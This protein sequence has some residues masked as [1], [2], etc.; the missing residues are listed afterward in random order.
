[1]AGGLANDFA[2]QRHECS[3]SGVDDAPLACA[4]TRH[5][6][7]WHVCCYFSSVRFAEYRQLIGKQGEDLAAEELRRRGYAILARRYRTRFGEIDIVAQDHD[8][9]VFV[10]VKARRSAR[11]GTAAESLPFWKQR[12]IAAMALDYLAW[13]DRLSDPCRFDL[14]AIDGIG[15]SRL[16][17]R[18]IQGA[19]LAQRA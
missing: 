15:S 5:V 3:R 17:I 11:F 12:R 18:V 7:V 14:V 2:V 8:S 9:V 19:F 13:S 1:V 6:P 10:E 4:S 16:D